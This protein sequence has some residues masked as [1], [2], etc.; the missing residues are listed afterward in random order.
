MQRDQGIW[1]RYKRTA[2]KPFE[3]AA[4][5]YLEEFDGKDKRRQALALESLIPYIGN[6]PIFDVDDGALEQ[7]KHDRLNGL[8][9]F[10]KKA[11]AGT[12]NKEITT[13][14]TVLNRAFKDW[15]WIPGVPRLRRVKGPTR[16]GYPI[17]WDEQARLFSALP[18]NWERGCALFAVNTG[19]R[20]AELFGLK[21][22]D[23][24]P[25][26]EFETYVFILRETKN[27]KDRPVICNSIAKRAV[28][29]QRD[30]G[31]RFVFPS[32]KPGYKGGRIRATGK[33]WSNAWK[34]AGLPSD[35][36]I[37]KGIHNLRMTFATRLRAAGVPEED[38]NLLLGHNN[39][40]M[41]QHY[42]MPDIER[43]LEMAERVT[44]RKDTVVLRS[45]AS[46]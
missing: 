32:R 14:V 40:S 27:G 7:F 12:V 26:P 28:E 19:V 21:W 2:F 34:R 9:A 39:V 17:T 10:D 41:A 33:T 22:T 15:R 46:A 3:E 45:V 24:V 31:S 42:A 18:T 1:D 25:I 29:Y 35:P 13:A 37:R 30:N 4:A 5:K 16:V 36:L 8:G 6:V 20:K 11:M 23:L 43:L 38:R 44:V